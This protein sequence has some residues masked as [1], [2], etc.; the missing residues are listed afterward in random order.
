M[1]LDK[2]TLTYEEKVNIAIAC[3]WTGIGVFV[4]VSILVWVGSSFG[5]TETYLDSLYRTIIW[6]LDTV[7]SY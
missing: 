5:S 4:A 3:M 7:R 2:D 1:L 6:I